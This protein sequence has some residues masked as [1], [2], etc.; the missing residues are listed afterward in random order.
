MEVLVDCDIHSASPQYSD[1]LPYLDPYWT[2]FTKHSELKGTK[3]FDFPVNRWGATPK[4]HPSENG[5]D[6]SPLSISDFAIVNC[7]YELEWLRNP[8]AAGAFAAAVNDWIHAKYLSTSPRLWGAMV[9][10][11][12][13]PN[14]AIQEVRRLAKTNQWAHVLVPARSSILYGNRYYHEL[15]AEL[16]RLGL[17]LAIHFGGGPGGPMTSSGWH[18]YLCEEYI[19]MPTVLQAQ[20]ISLLAEGVFERFPNFRVIGLGCGFSWC[21]SLF[22]RLDR[23][24]KGLSREIPWS[25]ALPSEVLKRRFSLS[26]NPSYLAEDAR[27]II[28]PLFEEFELT[29]MIVYSSDYPNYHPYESID[30]P[31][32]NRCLSAESIKAILKNNARKLYHR[33]LGI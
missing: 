17:P 27:K 20:L 22:W 28:G 6:L 32:L 23:E 29:N 11:S 30:I 21:W 12:H 10:P 19:G 18:N 24:W 15:W 9:I 8:D 1:L 5:V 14:V 13:L 31:F 3:A 4:E 16:D 2:D 33:A 26:L 7:L 25:Q